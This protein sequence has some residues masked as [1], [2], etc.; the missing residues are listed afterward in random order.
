MIGL[1]PDDG[2]VEEMSCA[3]SKKDQSLSTAFIPTFTFIHAAVL[4]W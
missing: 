1:V 3:L 4:A 2:V